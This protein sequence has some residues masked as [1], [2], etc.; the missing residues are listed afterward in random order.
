MRGADQ[1]Q[2]L[3]YSYVTMERRI[4]RDHPV[5]KIRELVDGALE[6]MDKALDGMYATRG[7]ASIAPERL[8]R[9][10]F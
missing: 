6:R 7:R 5:R 3:M 8:L 9:A 10:S 2:G 4:S 1:K